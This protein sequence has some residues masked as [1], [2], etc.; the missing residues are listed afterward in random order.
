MQRVNSP[1]KQAAHAT[2]SRS[3]APRCQP[4]SGAALLQS[5]LLPWT[6]QPNGVP[7][8]HSQKGRPTSQVSTRPSCAKMG[9]VP[10]AYAEPFAVWARAAAGPRSPGHSRR[11]ARTRRLS[12]QERGG[13]RCGG[14]REPRARGQKHSHSHAAPVAP[15]AAPAEAALLGE[16]TGRRGPPSQAPVRS[17]CSLLPASTGLG[18]P[19]L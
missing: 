13:C 8:E 11:R 18:R 16:E 4:G 3:S 12:V 9:S 2:G 15:P 5:Q 14:V 19:Q 10:G 1:E 17:G 6:S 7:R